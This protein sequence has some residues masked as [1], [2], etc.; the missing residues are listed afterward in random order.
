MLLVSAIIGQTTA[1]DALLSVRVIFALVCVIVS[2]SLALAVCVGLL[3]R[4]QVISPV[5]PETSV[6]PEDE[7]LPQ[8]DR[9]R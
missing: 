7:S 4:I 9:E 6:E 1:P 3:R 8:P 2:S 5:R